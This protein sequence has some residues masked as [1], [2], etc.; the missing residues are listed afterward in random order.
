[1]PA[2]ASKSRASSPSLEGDEELKE[3]QGDAEQPG[4]FVSPIY[5]DPDTGWDRQ[6]RI[7]SQGQEHTVMQEVPLA[8]PIEQEALAE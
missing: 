5:T 1:M 4:A 3:D 6:P 7:G 2:P 8:E